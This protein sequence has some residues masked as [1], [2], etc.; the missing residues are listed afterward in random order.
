MYVFTSTNS[1]FNDQD[2]YKLFVL[3]QHYISKI[4]FSDFKHFTDYL[5]EVLVE[6][7]F[8]ICLVEYDHHLPL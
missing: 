7:L 8:S 1:N 6:V 3:F 2:E 4:F 5:N